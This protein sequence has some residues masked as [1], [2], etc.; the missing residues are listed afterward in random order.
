MPSDAAPRPEYPG[1]PS[2]RSDWLCLNGQWSFEID[3][4]D[5]GEP[6]GLLDRDLADEITVPFC[7][8]S[9]LSGIGN[10]DFLNA[11]WYRRSVEV[12]D[13]WAGRRVLLHFQA[14]DDEA[15]VWSGSRG[16]T[17]PPAPSPGT[18]AGPPPSPATWA[19]WRAG[20]SPSPFAPGTIIAAPS[21][22]ASSAPITR[23]TAAST[24]APPASGNRSGSNPSPSAPDSTGP[25][26]GRMSPTR[27]FTSN[28]PHRRRPGAAH[29]RPASPSHPQ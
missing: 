17:R 15:T 28:S 5:S 1:P 20:R 24:P 3:Q 21:P 26:S 8:E 29:A 23:T 25:A 18:I 11:V 27:A 9:E 12:P 7:P 13:D 19:R 22:V 6:R 4:G 16:R 14:V 2:S 10:T